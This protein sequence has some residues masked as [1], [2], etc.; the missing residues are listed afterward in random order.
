VIGVPRSATASRATRLALTLAALLGGRA[1]AQV[2]TT[3][4]SRFDAGPEGWTWTSGVGWTAAGGNPGGFLQFVDR[5][6]NFNG[7]V[8][9]PAAYRGD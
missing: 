9:A 5:G 2:C 1:G 3:E 4:V 7:W 8:V 6:P